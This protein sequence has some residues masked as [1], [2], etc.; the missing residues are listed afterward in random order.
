MSDI[1]VGNVKTHLGRRYGGGAQR[2]DGGDSVEEKPRPQRTRTPSRRYIKEIQTGAPIEVDRIRWTGRR[3]GALR[4]VNCVRLQGVIERILF[5]HVSLYDPLYKV[6]LEN[7]KAPGRLNSVEAFHVVATGT[8]PGRRKELGIFI[9]VMASG[10]DFVLPDSFLTS[11][12]V[13]FARVL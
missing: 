1:I 12:Q 7:L 11:C 8:V 13:A 2:S 3:N 9:K 5:N 6:L 10:H 4:A